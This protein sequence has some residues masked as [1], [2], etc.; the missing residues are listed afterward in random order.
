MTSPDRPAPTIIRA[1]PAD[2]H[3][4]SVAALFDEYRVHYGEPAAPAETHAW[5]TEQVSTGR[6]SVAAVLDGP[7]VR[8]IITVAV[9]PASL[10]LGTAWMVRDLF[11]PPRA[12]RQG[13]ARAL[14][15]H[16]VGAARDAGALRVSLQTE[17]DNTAA[18]TLYAEAGFRPVTGLELL[19]LTVLPGH[20]RG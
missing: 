1:R 19:N 17:I 6:M 13:I 4:A 15:H 9:M 11:V 20:E 10:T 18:L 2:E 8:G 14:L 16:V 7:A 5:L 3:F 12:R